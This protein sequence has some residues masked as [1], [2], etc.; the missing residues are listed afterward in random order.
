[1]YSQGPPRAPGAGPTHRGQGPD[2]CN[3]R[4]GAPLRSWTLQCKVLRRPEEGWPRMAVGTADTERDDRAGERTRT[5]RAILV[6][7]V[8]LGVLADGALR[9]APDG[10]GWTIWVVALAFAAVNV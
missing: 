9:N 10:L 5:A 7:A 1:M 8:L 6:A 2:R 3:A 4:H